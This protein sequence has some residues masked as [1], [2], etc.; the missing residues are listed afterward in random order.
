MDV[1]ATPDPAGFPPP[2]DERDPSSP[3][4]EPAPAD[5]PGELVPVERR[6][7]RR[8][9][10]EALVT[11]TSETCLYA[12]ISEDISEG[13]I[14]I[15]TLAPPPI[16]EL[17]QVKIRVDRVGVPPVTAPGRVVWHRTDEQG[18]VTGCGVAFVG[19]DRATRLLLSLLGR[20]ANQEPLL[21]DL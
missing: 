9:R 8:I 7:S 20:W 4:G 15:A 13:G 12:G 17:I 3:A 16:G 21:W 19:A 5:P 2:P 6:S 18:E 14:F 10:M 11:A 1:R